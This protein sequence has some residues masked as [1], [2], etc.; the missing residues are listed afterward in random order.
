M[1][2]RGD[3]PT[4]VSRDPDLGLGAPSRAFLSEHDVRRRYKRM[5]KL[6][7]FWCSGSTQVRT[8]GCVFVHMGL[9][10]ED[11]GKRV[12]RIWKGNWARRDYSFSSAV[13]MV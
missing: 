7:S 8:G 12:L 3:L 9:L 5:G 4:R 1:H 11:I 6:H 10:H 13:D 2:V